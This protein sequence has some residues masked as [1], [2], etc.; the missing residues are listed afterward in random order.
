MQIT[1]D[2]EWLLGWIKLRFLSEPGIAL[3]HFTNL[4][5]AVNYPISKARG[6]YWIARALQDLGRK[7]E[8]TKWYK[9]AAE[10]P[11][12]YYGQLASDRL[13]KKAVVTIN[14]RQNQ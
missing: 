2:A 3:K 12:A 1:P 5:E 6:A 8:A 9:N 14:E 10:Y 13:G 11:T 7:D 4:Y